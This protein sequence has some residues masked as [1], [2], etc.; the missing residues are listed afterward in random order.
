MSL[1]DGK[2]GRP[3]LVADY[4]ERLYLYSSTVT[5]ISWILRI[6]S[7]ELRLR[8]HAYERL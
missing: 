6:D 8:P 2:G 7:S 3:R 5:L 4:K 1:M